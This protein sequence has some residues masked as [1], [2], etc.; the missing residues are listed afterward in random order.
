MGSP[1][2]A[3]SRPGSGIKGEGGMRPPLPFTNAPSHHPPPHPRH[4]DCAQ[5]CV[6][7]LNDIAVPLY[8]GSQ[9]HFKDVMLQLS[10]R[11]FRLSHRVEQERESLAGLDYDEGEEGGEGPP[12]ER[13][14]QVGHQ[15][16]HQICHEIC[17]KIHQQIW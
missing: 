4:P 16:F 8:P 7:V 17:P 9:V 13:Q 12:S 15:V 1:R 10:K 3:P 2:V 5:H 11:A 6:F 14:H